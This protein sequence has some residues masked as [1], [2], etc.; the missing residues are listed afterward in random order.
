V[1]HVE[2]ELLSLPE[3]TSSPSVFSVVHVVRF[4]V[5]SVMFYRSLF[6]I[7]Y[8]SFGHCIDGF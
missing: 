1:L 6:V 4:L 2:Q 5:F 7:L 3:Y 8:F